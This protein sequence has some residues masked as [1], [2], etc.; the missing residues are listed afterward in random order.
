MTPSRTDDH[1][2]GIDVSHQPAFISDDWDL[3]SSVGSGGSVGGLAGAVGLPAGGSTGTFLQKL[4]ATDYD[5][6]WATDSTGE[7]NYLINQ[8]SGLA[9]AQT[10]T[11]VQLPIRTIEA[12]DNVEVA[13]SADG[14]SIVIGATGAATDL[15]SL[16]SG[17]SIALAKDGS[18][19]QVRSFISSNS[20]VDISTNENNEI[21]FTTTAGVGEANT[22]S[23]ANG[24]GIGLAMA[25]SGIVLPF[26]T[27]YS[28]DGTVTFA[29]EADIIDVRAAAVGPIPA[30]GAEDQVLTKASGDDYDYGWADAETAGGSTVPSGGTTGQVLTKDSATDFDYSWSTGGGGATYGRGGLTCLDEVYGTLTSTYQE[31]DQ[32]DGTRWIADTN[33]D[34]DTSNGEFEFDIAGFWRVKLHMMATWASQFGGHTGD[35]RIR[36]RNTDK[37]ENRDYHEFTFFEIDRVNINFEDV[38]EVDAD[39]TGDDWVIQMYS[40]TLVNSFTVHDA[41]LQLEYLGT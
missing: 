10:K 37:S 30:G 14:D 21:D 16:G 7:I 32:W 13:F 31:L 4:S 1:L 11:G 8:G 27:L 29:D 36:I 22:T 40:S 18:S 25:K 9:I 35:I 33:A 28:S 6:G 12:G 39:E 5:V 41:H 24:N 20:S 34:T 17:A 26:K 15:V 38:F 2:Y 3:M 23:N 19:L